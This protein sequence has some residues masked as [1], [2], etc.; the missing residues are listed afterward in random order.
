MTAD[1]AGVFAKA[2]VTGVVKPVLDTP[3]ATIKC[4]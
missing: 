1:T 4:E 3:V 2:Y